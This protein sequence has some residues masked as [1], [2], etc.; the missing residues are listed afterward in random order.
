MSFRSNI[1]S[2]IPSNIRFHYPIRHQ[3]WHPIRYP[4]RHSLWH[5]IRHFIRRPICHPIRHLIQNPIQHPFRHQLV[6]WNEWLLLCRLIVDLWAGVDTFRQKYLC[7]CLAKVKGRL[8]WGLIGQ[9][10]R[11]LQRLQLWR[12]QNA[13]S[14][15]SHNLSSNWTPTSLKALSLESK[16]TRK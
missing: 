13:S 4:I 3:I 9:E 14:S 15:G 1:H 2:D 5:P 11:R 7:S 10:G 16:L 6:H 12:S 8:K